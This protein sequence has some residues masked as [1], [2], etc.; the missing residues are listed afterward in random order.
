MRIGFDLRPIQ[1]SSQ[2][3]GIGVYIDHLIKTIAVIDKDNEYYFITLADKK[4]PKWDF[5]STFNYKHIELSPPFKEH[6]NLL[7]DKLTLHK[8]VE[9]Y[10]LDVVHFTS[11]F[12]LKIHFDLKRHNCRSVLTV[13]DLTPIYYGGLIFRNKRAV[14]KPV[15]HSLLNEVQNAGAIISVSENTK[16]DLVEKLNIP[17]NKITNIY[18]AADEMLKPVRDQE[19]LIKFKQKYSLPDKFVL[20]VGGLSKHKNINS[21]LE[22]MVLLENEYLINIPLVIVGR[23]DSF[24]YVDLNSK[25]ESLHLKDKV[26]FPGFLTTEELADIYSLTSAFVL[27]SLY[28]G[29]GLPLLEAMACGAPSAASNVSSMPEIGGE[30]VLYFN[31]NNIEEIAETIHNIL[32]SEEISDDL[33][34]KGLLRA[35]FFSWKRCAQETVRVYENLY[36]KVSGGG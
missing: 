13:H 8:I 23:I 26:I 32:S 20:Y 30:A 1:L 25:I 33:R 34:K 28:E 6:L 9:Q 3:L 24:H 31:P 4:L 35:K 10:R 22:A 36:Q 27:P 21:L 12:E 29:F 19:R 14:L 7:W 2:V 11:P 15:F 18:L 16:K 5:P 17:S